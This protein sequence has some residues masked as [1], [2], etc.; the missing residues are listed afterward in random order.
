M[1]LFTETYRV[2]NLRKAEGKTFSMPSGDATASSLYCF[3]L[4]TVAG[5]PAIYVVLP[6]VMAGR[7]YY[8]CHYLGDVLAGAFIGTMWG[9]VSLLS[10]DQIWAP[11]GRAMLGDDTFIP[12]A[13]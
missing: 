8:Q 13:I 5:L 1:E 6:F 12:A 9:L 2:G 11:L 3:V 10:F 7:I 4:A